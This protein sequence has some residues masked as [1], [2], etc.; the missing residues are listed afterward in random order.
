MHDLAAQEH[1]LHDVELVDECEVLVD[2]VD[3]E[4]ARV[5]DGAQLGLGAL[6]EEPALIGLLEAG[7]DL[8]QRRLAGA[9]VPQQ[10]EHLALAQTQVDVA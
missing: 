10:P 4:F 8:D 6:D 3:P 1:V 2:A 7:E 5:I 9:V